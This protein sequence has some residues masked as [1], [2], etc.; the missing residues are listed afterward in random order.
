[1]EYETIEKLVQRINGPYAPDAEVS[2]GTYAFEAAEEAG[3]GFGNA[4]LEAHLNILHEAG[5]VFDNDKALEVV[6]KL[7]GRTYTVLLEDGTVGK[8]QKDSLLDGDKVTVTLQDG[9]GMLIEK[10]G[11][12]KEI[13]DSDC[14]Q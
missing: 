2:A 1:M 6:R 9:N 10:C 11:R 4:E 12:V 7:I 14:P 8:V 5:A 13:L 3:Y